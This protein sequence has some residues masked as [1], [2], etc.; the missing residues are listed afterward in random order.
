MMDSN[1]QETLYFI[2]SAFTLEHQN[3]ERIGRF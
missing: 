2:Y 3:F 1:L